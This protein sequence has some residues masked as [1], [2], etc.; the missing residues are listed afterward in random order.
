MKLLD[1]AKTLGVSYRTAW[2]Y[3]HSGS[4]PGAYQMPS[5]T[6]IVPEVIIPVADEIKVAVYTRVSSSENKNNL[7]TQSQRVLDYCAARGYQVTHVIKEIGS[8][9]ND[10][11]K[12]FLSLLTD[13]SI[14]IIVVEHKD[15]A[16]R[17]GFNYLQEIL[18]TKNR[19]I[20]VIN[21]A[22]CDKEDLMADLIAIITSFVARY[23]GQRRATRK[24]E[25]IIRELNS[26]D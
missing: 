6:I 5:G 12:K 22:E 20:E 25:A 9:V 15:R 1:Y 4:I 11:R 26:V 10:K 3:F 19:R 2:R 21:T 7:E 23:Y 18:A 14:H 13:D 24:T 16:T 17:F 8:G